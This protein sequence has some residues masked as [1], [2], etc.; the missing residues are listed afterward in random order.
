MLFVLAAVV[1]SIDQE[2]IS[3]QKAQLVEIVGNCLVVIWFV[4]GF[5]LWVKSAIHWWRGRQRYSPL[6]WAIWGFLLVTLSLLVVFVYYPRVVRDE[7]RRA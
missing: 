6:P 7:A 1:A 3:E 5:P 2:A 4:A